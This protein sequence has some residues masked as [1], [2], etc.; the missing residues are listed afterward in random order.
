[1]KRLPVLVVPPALLAVTLLTA[2]ARPPATKTI[3]LTVLRHDSVKQFDKALVASV[4]KQ[5]SKALQEINS[6]DDVACDVEFVQQG[7]VGEFKGVGT[8]VDQATFNKVD[9]LGAPYHVKVVKEIYWCGGWLPEASACSPVGIAQGP[10]PRVSII[11]E[12]EFF[13]TKPERDGVMIAHEYGHNRGL[14]HRAANNPLYVMNAGVNENSRSINNSESMRY[15]GLSAATPAL[16]LTAV[17]TF[18]SVEPLGPEKGDDAPLMPV[19]EFVHLD[20]PQGV[21]YATASR[22]T[23]ADAAK[24]VP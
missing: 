19:V 4:F 2:P 8:I 23:K 10:A 6:T 16:D 18:V 13:T 17:H 11:I 5:A 3:S 7:R 24:L 9:G 14:N 22:Y 15:L 21:P 1:M 20:Y 12:E